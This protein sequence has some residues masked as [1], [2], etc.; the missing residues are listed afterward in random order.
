M[1]A[2]SRAERIASRA[3]GRRE[4]GAELEPTRS[5]ILVRL[6]AVIVRGAK[7]Y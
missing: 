4:R 2:T 1:G 3:V 6:Q 5:R 7:E